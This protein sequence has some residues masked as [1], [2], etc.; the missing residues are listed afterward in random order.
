MKILQMP[1]LRGACVKA[2]AFGRFLYQDLA[3]PLPAEGRFFFDGLAR[4][5]YRG[6]GM[7]ILVKVFY[8]SLGSWRNAVRDLCLRSSWEALEEALVKSCRWPYMF[9]YRSL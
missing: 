7:K 5:S 3:R 9:P 6:P 8:K 4:F 1:C 2:L